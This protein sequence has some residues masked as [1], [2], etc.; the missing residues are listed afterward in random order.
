MEPH[1]QGQG[2]RVSRVCVAGPDTDG[3]YQEEIQEDDYLQRS[4]V[5][6]VGDIDQAAT[7]GKVSETNF[8]QIG[9]FLRDQALKIRLTSWAKSRTHPS[10]I[11]CSREVIFAP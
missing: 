3:A 8:V 9:Q 4:L 1:P 5:C 6:A 11:V 10:E 7:G 2:Q